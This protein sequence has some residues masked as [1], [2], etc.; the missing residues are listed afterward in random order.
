MADDDDTVGG[1]WHFPPASARDLQLGLAREAMRHHDFQRA[2]LELEEFL[3]GHP[4]DERALVL[5]AGACMELRD[6]AVARD[7]WETLIDLGRDRASTW[8]QVAV[9]AFEL[10]DFEAAGLAADNAIAQDDDAGEAWALRGD[11]QARIGT[12]D[13]AQHAFERAYEVSPLMFALPLTLELADAREV[14]EQAL[15][16]LPEDVAGFWSAVPVRFEPF[17]S[18]EELSATVPPLTP[19]VLALYEGEPPPRPSSKSRPR[20]LR[21][22]LGNLVRHES[23]DVA[24]GALADALESECADWRN[25]VDVEPR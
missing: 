25:P 21:I 24:V 22:Y 14:L 9:C 6:W 13:E 11:V 8:T 17:P 10:G 19:R 2:V 23:W 18:A 3:D 5:L 1:G 20:A 15:R 16:E 4:D 7:A 12:A